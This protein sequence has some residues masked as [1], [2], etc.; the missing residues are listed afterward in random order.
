MNTT[1][2]PGAFL[3]STGP[4]GRGEREWEPGWSVS[5]GLLGL[6][7]A[8]V[9]VLIVVTLIGVVYLAIGV[10]DPEDNISYM[11]AAIGAQDLVMAAAAVALAGGF[12]PQTFGRLGLRRF[13]P[14]ALGWA[15]LGFLVYMI[16]SALYAQLVKPPDDNL[17]DQLGATHGTGLAI[18]SAV[19]VVGVAPF[20]EELFFRG[21]VYQSL[22]SRMGVIGA[23]LSSGLIFGAI[24]FKPEFLVPLAVLGVVLALL[25]E[26]TGSLWPCIL[27]HAFNNAIV[28]AVSL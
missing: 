16:I 2:Q 10:D 4:S 3:P 8:L 12:S 25:M 20:V 13:R 9:V 22:R 6:V 28:F 27:V 1:E 15:A 17:L 26:K 23:A 11:F 19:F 21:F 24:H 5:R 18:L 7:S 14:S